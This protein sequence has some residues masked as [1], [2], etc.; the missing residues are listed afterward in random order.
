L[1]VALSAGI[2]IVPTLIKNWITV[3]NPVS[4]FLNLVFPNHYV[5]VSFEEVLSESMRSYQ[6]HSPWELIYETTVGGYRT[7]G[8]LGPVFLLA[9]LS[10]F[11]LRFA[12]GRRLLLAAL[13]FLLPYPL[14]LGTRFL[15][16]AATLLAPGIA[17]GLGGTA[18]G[19][20][21]A[22]HGFTAWPARIS[23]RLQVGPW[24][25]SAIS[26]RADWAAF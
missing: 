18:M 1:L 26:L 7:Q 15:L 21:V 25:A 22:L 5:H 3:R 9:P 4:P 10:L 14:N 11:A 16:P 24:R 20:L 23:W 13:V 6:I 12:P 17:M 8:L 19:L 2:L